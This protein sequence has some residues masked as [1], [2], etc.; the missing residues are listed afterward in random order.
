MAPLPN[1]KVWY[2]LDRDTGRPEVKPPGVRYCYMQ[3][4]DE[5]VGGVE[6]V[7]RTRRMVSRPTVGLPMVCPSDTPSGHRAGMN[8]G[9]CGACF[10]D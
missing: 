4:T 5:A 6:L 7:F 9:Q 1:C 10:D 8:C 2:S 3:D